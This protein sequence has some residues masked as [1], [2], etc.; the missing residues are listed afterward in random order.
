MKH[1]EIDLIFVHDLVKKGRITVNHVH[2]LDQLTDL[3]TKPIPRQ[4]FQNLQSKIG[5]TDGTFI[6]QGHIRKAI[7]LPQNQLLTESTLASL[8]LNV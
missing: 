2:T 8:N 6:L 4:C 1:I 3:L 5:V 7:T